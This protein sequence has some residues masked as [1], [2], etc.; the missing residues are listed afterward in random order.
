MRS[1]SMI[2][3]NTL[4]EDSRSNGR[5]KSWGLQKMP[6][7]AINGLVCYNVEECNEIWNIQ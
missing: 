6:T 5:D 4:W 1:I 2:N 7:V 3:T